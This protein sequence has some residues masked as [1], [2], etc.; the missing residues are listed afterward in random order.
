MSLEKPKIIRIDDLV[1]GLKLKKRTIIFWCEEYDLNQHIGHHQSGN[2]YNEKVVFYL[3]LV[4][5]L[6]ESEFFSSKFIKKFITLLDQTGSLPDLPSYLPELTIK[7]EKILF[8]YQK[9]KIQLL[10][11][12]NP[13]EI[14]NQEEMNSQFEL[15]VAELQKKLTTHPENEDEIL[16]EIA[17]IYRLKLQ[18]YSE[19]LTYYLKV[20]EIDSP[21][22]KE[23]AKIFQEILVQKL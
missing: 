20:V 23:V 12:S 13:D 10:V 8:L 3:L 4:K 15:R 11:F 6:K 17:E 14:L 22:Y 16:M 7:L 18:R 1:T 2:S 19:A 5:E 21:K 9:G